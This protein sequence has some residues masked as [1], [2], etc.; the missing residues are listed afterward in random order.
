MQVGHTLDVRRPSADGDHGSESS[1][2]VVANKCS[3]RIAM[4][5]VQDMARVRSVCHCPVGPLCGSVLGGRLGG[6]FQETCVCSRIN[7]VD[8]EALRGSAR[9]SC[10]LR[11]LHEVSTC[12]T[13]YGLMLEHPDTPGDTRWT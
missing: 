3:M 13:D 11:V 1:N 9:A 7:S 2:E 8:G 6:R 5:A 12:T 10:S 4:V